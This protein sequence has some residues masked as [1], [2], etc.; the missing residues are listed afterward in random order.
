MH[1]LIRRITLYTYILHPNN[2]HS[3]YIVRAICSIPAATIFKRLITLYTTAASSRG[4]SVY[5]NIPSVSQS[6]N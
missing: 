2:S 5:Y 1:K 6:A 3:T 4:A